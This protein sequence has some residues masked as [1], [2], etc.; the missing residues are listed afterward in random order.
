MHHDFIKFVISLKYYLCF[1]IE[2]NEWTL[3]QNN[4]FYWYYNAQEII[5]Q[6]YNF[7]RAN[8]K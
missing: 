5:Y 7:V 3:R 1:I 8:L 4:Q 6:Y 2:I